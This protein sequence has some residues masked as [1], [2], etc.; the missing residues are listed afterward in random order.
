MAMRE[1]T[2]NSRRGGYRWRRGFSLALLACWHLVA[3]AEPHDLGESALRIDVEGTYELLIPPGD[4]LLEKTD[5]LGTS[6]ID[7]Q[8][9]P[10]F[11]YFP[12][13]DEYPSLM[14]IDTRQP[15]SLAAT[16]RHSSRSPHV[17]TTLRLHDASELPAAIKV[18]E[19][20]LLRAFTIEGDAGRRR[21]IE[22]STTLANLWADPNSPLDF[23]ASRWHF[24]GSFAL[25]LSEYLDA[26]EY[27]RRGIERSTISGD[28]WDLANAHNTLGLT[29]I[30]RGEYAAADSHLIIARDAW[31]P[32]YGEHT[33]N[34]AVS[35]LCFSKFRADLVDEAEP[36]YEAL[37]EQSRRLEDGLGQFLYL[38]NLAGILHKR[39]QPLRSL[40]RINEAL[41]LPWVQERPRAIAELHKTKGFQ[42]VRLGRFQEAMAYYE[43]ALTYARDT[44]NE[45]DALGLSMNIGVTY[46]FIGE[47]RQA[48]DLLQTAYAQIPEADELRQA[49]AARNLIFALEQL[50]AIDEAQAMHSELT[51]LGQQ[52]SDPK[53]RHYAQLASA[54]IAHNEGDHERTLE[55]YQYGEPGFAVNQSNAH[56]VRRVALSLATLGRQVEAYE[57]AEGLIETTEKI[58]SPVDSAQAFTLL[59]KLQRLEG[60]TSEATQSALTAIK[61]IESIRSGFAN[62]ELRASYQSTVSDAYA[63]LVDMSIAAGDDAAALEMA[64]RFRA[65]TLVDVLHKGRSAP[66]ANAPPALI[67]RR[68]VLRG[69]INE[70]EE[71]RQ[72]EGKSQSVAELLTE[73][74]VLDAEITKFDPRY[75]ATRRDEFL[76]VA[77]LQETMEV[78]T[79]ALQFHL[80][81]DQSAAWLIG[82]DTR[83]FVLLPD[84]GS[85]SELV[86]EVHENFAKRRRGGQ[87]AVTA[88]QLFL[89]PFQ[90]ELEQA[91]RIVIIPDGSLH[92]LPFE[93]LAL[94]ESEAPLLLGK[95]VSY[96]PS[97]TAL[98]LSRKTAENSAVKLVAMVDPVFG[99]QD[100]RLEGTTMTSETEVDPL[101][102]LRLSSREAEAIDTQLTDPDQL[103]TAEGFGANAEFLNSQS[104][105]TASILHLATHGFADDETPA[106]TGVML[107]RFDSE[108]RSVPGFVGLRDIYELRLSAELVTL[109]ACNTA[110]GRELSGEG[111]L[112]L[113]RA[114]M[115]AG[116]RRVVASLWPVSD[117][118]TAQLMEHFYEGL[119]RDN[120]AP[121]EAL[122]V[123]KLRLSKNPR[124]R[125]PY[126]WSGFILHGDWRPLR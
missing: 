44:G 34:P 80:G 110:L 70:I 125:H 21:V 2:Q 60:R 12:G 35:N 102:R 61:H 4:W 32:Y 73:L 54:V 3:A 43:K 89:G 121:D 77:G 29:Q 57:L 84:A 49:I 123:A 1:G 48:A 25:E 115:Y 79:R 10:E 74:D 113:T 38:K 124:F 33:P 108:G 87:A 26:I 39:K 71:A 16:V 27:S 78:G 67:E 11:D 19:G 13:Y 66:P 112:G 53:V 59:A 6:R 83:E 7:L 24:A 81:S 9:I 14:P 118:A 58:G 37:L 20:E 116:A 46:L 91:Q 97:L 92:Y 28:Q 69:Q 96:Q 88:G 50:D 52:S 55:L 111:L 68:A 56:R 23:S 107:S 105:S 85:I 126:Y 42:M 5:R 18:H 62:V 63:L 45:N 119:L 41:A 75:A 64:E 47:Y 72:T 100:S 114:F 122:A 36:C 65:Q 40:G 93:A 94:N 95:P 98:A 17:H 90:S 86:R 31:L 104:V 30:R 76:S 117:R 109:S 99:R 22:L 120:L 82:P 51:R 15:I 103:I 101:N 106:R 8:G